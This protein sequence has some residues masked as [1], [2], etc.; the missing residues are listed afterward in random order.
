MLVL[1]L[2]FYKIFPPKTWVEKFRIYGVNTE[3][4]NII[5]KIQKKIDDAFGRDDG[6]W[7]DNY[8]R[9]LYLNNQFICALDLMLKSFLKDKNQIKVK[10]TLEKIDSEWTLF[11]EYQPMDY[12]GR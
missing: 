5:E 1:I 8:E 12:I 10:E 4:I 9:L 2:W 3:S 6:N 7:S 11:E